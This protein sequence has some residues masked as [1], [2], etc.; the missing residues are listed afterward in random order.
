MLALALVPHVYLMRKIEPMV[1][2]LPRAEPPM[3]LH[4]QLF[5]VAAVISYLHLSLGG[6]G[7]ALV[8]IANV[9]TMIEYVSEGAPGV[10]LL[11]PSF[12]IVF[13]S[14]FA[15]YFLYLTLLKRKLQRKP[16]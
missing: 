13:G 12:G 14:L 15:G 4:D 2:Q 1:A 16:K 10:Q 11:W 7:G 9:K 8:V 5:G 3:S 6:F